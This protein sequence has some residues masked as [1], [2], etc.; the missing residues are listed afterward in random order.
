MASLVKTRSIGCGVLRRLVGCVSVLCISLQLRP[1]EAQIYHLEGVAVPENKSLHTLYAYYVYTHTDPEVPSPA[2]GS[3]FVK[4][5]GFVSHSTSSVRPDRDLTTYQGLQLSLVKYESFW[6]LINPT[7]FCCNAEDVKFKLCKAENQLLIQRPKPSKEGDKKGA[8]EFFSHTASFHA[9]ADHAHVDQQFQISETGA[10]IL[11]FSNCGGFDRAVVSGSIVVKNPYGFLPGNEY[12]RMPFYGWLCIFYTL[13]ALLWLVLSLRWWK[14]LFNIQSCIG[15]VILFGLIEAFTWYVF[16]SDWNASGVRGKFI[17]ILATMATVL[18]STFSYML[19]LVASLG[20]GVTRPYLTGDIIKKLQVFSFV[21]IVL[22]FI[23]ESVLSFRT[24]HTISLPLTLLISFPVT[25][26]NGI[27][28]FWVFTSLGDII[29]TL[30]DRRQNQKLILFQRLWRILIFVIT[31]AVLTVMLQVISMTRGISSRW[32][33][34][35]LFED[36]ATHI[37]FMLVLVVMM[38][39]WAPHQYSSRYAYTSQ[40]DDGDFEDQDV[41]AKVAEEESKAI[42]GDDDE[43]DDA[44]SFWDT[45]QDTISGSGA[46]SSTADRRPPGMPSASIVG[47]S[48]SSRRDDDLML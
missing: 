35:W 3:A 26:L 33:W 14:D 9:S 47:A 15:A 20:W 42:W 37:L 30:K 5:S 21:Y 13:L 2:A 22:D 31:V 4:F 8:E 18:K 17:F 23:R 48:S 45:T 34:Q 6:K 11:V 43:E 40:C 44:D 32:T 12:H 10:Y 25:L 28:F 39:L 41:L 24:S 36:G 19:V 29:E 27:I 16:F 7:K 38:Y 1:L 46:S